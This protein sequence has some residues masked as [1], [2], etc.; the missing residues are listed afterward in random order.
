L[1]QTEYDISLA[2]QALR[3][4]VFEAHNYQDCDKFVWK[5]TQ[6][7]L[8]QFVEENPREIVCLHER[9]Q[10]DDPSCHVY[11]IVSQKK[12]VYLGTIISKEKAEANF[13]RLVNNFPSKARQLRQHGP[14]AILKCWMMCS[15]PAGTNKLTQ[16][17]VQTGVQKYLKE[18]APRLAGLP[19]NWLSIEQQNAISWKILHEAATTAIEQTKEERIDVFLGEL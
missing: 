11:M 8:D 3:T 12:I 7:W 1:K 13:F 16:E 15:I 9:L 5:P 14:M 19:I 2:V 10:P 18:F 17:T 4:L 6:F